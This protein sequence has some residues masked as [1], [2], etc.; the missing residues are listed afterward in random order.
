VIVVLFFEPIILHCIICEDFGILFLLSV[1]A[2]FLWT[3]I[4]ESSLRPWLKLNLSIKYLYLFLPLTWSTTNLRP[5]ISNYHLGFMDHR[6][7]PDTE[8]SQLGYEE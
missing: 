4:Y 1:P 6:G 2:H 5:L 3:L 8:E 7:I